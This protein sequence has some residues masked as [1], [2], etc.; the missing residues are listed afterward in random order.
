MLAEDELNG[1]KFATLTI[2]SEIESIMCTLKIVVVRHLI[3]T[4]INL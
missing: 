3:S 4:T 2:H 1:L